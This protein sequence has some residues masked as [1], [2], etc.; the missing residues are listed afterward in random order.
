M[1][2]NL[3]LKKFKEPNGAIRFDQLIAIP[4]ANRISS[5]AKYDMRGTVTT[6]AVALTLAFEAMN[7]KNGMTPIQIV[8]LAEAIVDDSDEDKIAVEDLL[9]FCQKLTRGH[10]GNL[11]ES[12]D[13]LKFMGFFNKFRDERFAAGVAIRDA[14][15][16]EY[17]SLGDANAFDR[18]NPKDGSPFGQYM[19]HFRQ[20]SQARSDERKSRKQ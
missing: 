4:V 5:M 13:A 7:L 14:K 16:E 20:K 3:E 18:E 6:I 10:Y 17:K 8:D 19:N 12:M 15:V 2:I 11:Y 1:G 9:L